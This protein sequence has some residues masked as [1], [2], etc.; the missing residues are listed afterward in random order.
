MVTVPVMATTS[1]ELNAGEIPV[2]D[3]L[4]M[5]LP[6]KPCR[7]TSRLTGVFVEP[8]CAWT[9]R[10]QVRERKQYRKTPFISTYVFS[11]LA[12]VQVLIFG[13]RTYIRG[14]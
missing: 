6:A 12:M 7:E 13:G 4:M 2:I 3:Q 5:A 10:E 11:G 14:V 1:V 9:W 8:S